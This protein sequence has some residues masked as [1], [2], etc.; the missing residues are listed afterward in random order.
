MPV[1][2]RL[3]I[4]TGL[5]GPVS[6]TSHVCSRSAGSVGIFHQAI[7]SS[8]VLFLCERPSSQ[9]CGI[10]RKHWPVT[11]TQPTASVIALWPPT[12]GQVGICLPPGT[13]VGSARRRSRSR[14]KRRD[15]INDTTTTL[16]GAHLLTAKAPQS[17]IHHR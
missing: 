12:V 10:N 14:K 1:L 3:P 4:D 9:N 15:S 8:Q 11:T 6:E 7:P 17:P 5:H 2:F 16:T 13:A